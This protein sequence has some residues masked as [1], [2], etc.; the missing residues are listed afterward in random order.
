LLWDNVASLVH[1]FW[2]AGYITVVAGS[3]INDH[4]RITPTRVHSPA[5]TGAWERT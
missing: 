5:A 4:R 3:F 1:N 2:Q